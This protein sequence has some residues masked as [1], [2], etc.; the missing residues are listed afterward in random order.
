MKRQGEGKTALSAEIARLYKWYV[1]AEE[2]LEETSKEMMFSEDGLCEKGERDCRGKSFN[3]IPP[4][5][6]EKS[7][8]FIRETVLPL[9]IETMK[10]RIEFLVILLEEGEYLILEGEVDKVTV[11]YP[12]GVL[13][14][15]THPDVCLMSHKDMETADRAFI[16]GYFGSAVASYM[17]GL[18]LYRSG[19]YLPED[20]EDLLDR[21][22]KMK[23]VREF[24][25]ALGLQ[26]RPYNALRTK[27]VN[28]GWTP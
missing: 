11:P 8:S 3:E 28:W 12:R 23:K 4:I 16:L 15:H 24:S 27:I 21:S 1:E 7:I 9:A 18:I 26:T 17:C 6:E 5:L 13:A 10:N 2:I 14:I 20:R 25:V 19:P 22:R